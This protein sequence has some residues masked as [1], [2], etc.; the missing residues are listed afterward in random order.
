MSLSPAACR[1]LNPGTV[2]LRASA[3]TAGTARLCQSQKVILVS[4]LNVA[5]ALVA[6]ADKRPPWGTVL[7]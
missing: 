6:V 7:L 4:C 3:K 2:L 1:V 5:H